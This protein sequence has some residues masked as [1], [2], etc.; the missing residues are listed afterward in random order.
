MVLKI[1]IKREPSLEILDMSI[2]SEKRYSL[3]IDGCSKAL[4]TIKNDNI[5]VNLAVCGP[6]YLG[7]FQRLLH[8]LLEL[9]LIVDK[10]KGEK[11]VKSTNSDV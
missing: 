2:A 6:M 8:G 10:N 3:H 4:L 1:P 5:Q 11:Y 9:S 7:E